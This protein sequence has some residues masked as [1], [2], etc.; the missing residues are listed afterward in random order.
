MHFSPT[1]YFKRIIPSYHYNINIFSNTLYFISY[2]K[3]YAL[4]LIKE[5]VLLY[6]FFCKKLLVFYLFI[7]CLQ[8][9]RE[10]QEDYNIYPLSK[11]DNLSIIELLKA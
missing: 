2:K 7:Y 8:F 1:F 6:I 3:A 11:K 10:A 9:A 5:N 4:F